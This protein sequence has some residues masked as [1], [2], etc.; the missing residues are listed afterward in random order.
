[1]IV[2]VITDHDDQPVAVRLTE[3]ECLDAVLDWAKR[4]IIKDDERD[5]SLADVM[6]VKRYSKSDQ[7]YFEHV[8]EPSFYAVVF[9]ADETYPYG[10]LLVQMFD[11]DEAIDY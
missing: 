3:Q 6:R 4:Y 1:M 2:Y 9:I 10:S 5:S 7:S 8:S 11:T